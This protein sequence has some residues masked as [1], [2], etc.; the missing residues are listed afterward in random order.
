[1]AT[2]QPGKSDLAEAPDTEAPKE[3]TFQPSANDLTEA[4]D[5]EAPEEAT[6]QPSDSDLT[7]APESNA[8]IETTSTAQKRYEERAS[9]S[10]ADFA[11][12][13]GQKLIAAYNDPDKSFFY[14]PISVW[15]PLAALT[16]AA[17]DRDKLA[18]LEALGVKNATQKMLNDYVENML[19]DLEITNSDSPLK[20]ANALY[21]SNRETVN[22][23]FRSIF[24]YGYHGK[25]FNLNFASPESVDAINNWASEHTG[26]LI[27]NLIDSRS[28]NESI[29]V[30]V[31]NAAYFSDKWDLEFDTE[32]TDP[33]LFHAAS[34]DVTANFMH[35]SSDNLTYFEDEH[36]QA[37]SLSYA[38]GARM[39]IMLPK[40]ET[41]NDFLESLTVWRFEDI[42]R[43][44]R[45]CAGTLLL[46]RFEANIDIDLRD[47]LKG[48]GV[49][50]FGT[51]LT[52]L[53]E[54]NS[55]ATSSAKQK[56]VIKVDEE[57][58]TAAAV[59]YFLG[60][61]GSAGIPQPAKSFRMVCDK[62][63]AFVLEKD[64]QILFMGAVNNPEE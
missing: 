59:T 57:G 40:N 15:L 52:G 51:E 47:A 42:K 24:E 31:L 56:A 53:V 5:T 46:P 19:S 1:M 25:V 30:S 13:L 36:I 23:E 9:I 11:F 26:G 43:N 38:G 60:A 32:L 27:P 16:N 18:L 54:S 33:R 6:S 34:G 39:W 35:R 29:A 37:I 10:E 21:V 7:E 28:F 64:D 20:I 41:A 49:S 50:I 58:T 12:S 45:E 63:F 17:D 2:L 62:P 48:I 8:P 4:P 14:S 22:E 55:V 3:A 44:S 61:P